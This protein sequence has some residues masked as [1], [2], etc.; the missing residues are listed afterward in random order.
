[1]LPAPISR[2]FPATPLPQR[3]G[4]V[5]LVLALHAGLG[6]V[7]I[8]QPEQ[9]T[10]VLNELSV[11]VAMQ[12]AETVMPQAQPEP[13]QPPKSQPKIER[14][15]QPVARTAIPEPAQVTSQDAPQPVAAA[16]TVATSAPAA[17][18]SAPVADSEPDFKATYLNNPRPAYPMVARRMGWEG[19]VILNVE[20]LAE[21]KCGGINVF[22]SSGHEVLDN[23]A[24]NTVRN[25]RFVP[26]HHIGHPITQW[27]KVP[28]NFSLEDNE[29]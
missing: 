26:A 23:A 21:G 10:V 4:V 2:T 11:S 25:W 14:V 29:A 1:M 12:Q 15:V 7:W 5:L 6:A 24:V 27:F 13:V 3:V 8:L 17:V 28:V 22:R 20:V 18:A 9:P 19:R 16:T